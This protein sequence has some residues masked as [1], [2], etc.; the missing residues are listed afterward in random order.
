MPGEVNSKG[1][2]KGLYLAK[3]MDDLKKLA[4]KT[5]SQGRVLNSSVMP[6]TLAK[7]FE[8][9]EKSKLDRDEERAFVLLFRYSDT[10]V[11]AKKQAEDPRFFD[12][13]VKPKTF[14]KC[15]M[16]MEELEQSLSQRYEEMNNP[17]VTNGVDKKVIEKPFDDENMPNGDMVTNNIIKCVEL[18]DFIEDNVCGALLDANPV[19][20]IV[21]CRSSNDFAESKMNMLPMLKDRA[22]RLVLLNI[23]DEILAEGLAMTSLEKKL[24][25]DTKNA[26]KLRKLVKRVILMDWTS[27]ELPKEANHKLT[28]LFNAMWKW[29]NT[30]DRCKMT[31][32]ILKGGYY[33]WV[34]HY[35]QLTTNPNVE[36]PKIYSPHTTPVRLNQIKIDTAYSLDYLDDKK[37]S[38]N[39]A[40][41]RVRNG[42]SIPV[43]Q[44]GVDSVGKP[45]SRP[46]PGGAVPIPS[47]DRTS[48][49][50][51]NGVINL[52][53]RKPLAP[54]NASNVD[55]MD[56]LRRRKEREA[57]TEMQMSLVLDAE[58]R[59]KTMQIEAEKKDAELN[60][61]RRENSELKSRKFVT[62]DTI[63]NGAEMSQKRAISP[64]KGVGATDT[65]FETYSEG[66][67]VDI[68]MRPRQTDRT[69]SE[70]KSTNG[71]LLRRSISG[72]G[73]LS[74]SFS[75]P[76]IAQLIDEDEVLENISQN[77]NRTSITSRPSF[78]R[79]LKPAVNSKSS[80]T[81]FFANM[82]RNRNFSPVYGISGQA[83]TGLKN[84]GN[85]C[86][87][88]SVIQCL[89]STNE[90]AC[91]F[92]SE[93]YVDHLNRNSKFGSRGEL[94]EEF[95]ALVKQLW[96]CQYKSLAPKDLKQ[97]I[98]TH[99]RDF[100][101][102]E[103][104]D[105]HE[106]FTMFMDKISNDL[107]IAT[108]DNT[109]LKIPDDTQTHLAMKKFWAHHSSIM[110][111]IISA[112]FEGLTMSTL[113]CSA[114]G[115]KSE[116]FEVFNSLSL[117]IPPGNR[118]TLNDCLKLFSE[119]EVIR[120][121]AAWDC[122]TCKC[123]REA[124]KRI[125]VCRLP[126]I[127]VIHLKRFSYDGMWRQ[128]LQTSVDFPLEDLS[129]RN[130]RYLNQSDSLANTTYDL[131]GII[132]HSGTM[133]GGH[134]IAHGK[135]IHRGKWYKFDDHEVSE[136]SKADVKTHAAYM[137]FYTSKQQLNGSS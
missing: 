116:T 133:D 69:L 2:A 58:N 118:V 128:K 17:P 8:A 73:G 100:V 110:S 10:Y 72:G 29:D 82:S 77:V 20:L 40:D 16:D 130:Y 9:A 43:N 86:F 132:N 1:L 114:C 121:E 87:M 4:E 95:G 136:I 11:R 135:H 91:Y 37:P 63:G 79:T 14:G 7:V 44:N 123:K 90:L 106:F 111:S 52:D 92:T 28:V 47:I 24:N 103:Q 6:A 94:A 25:V 126:K 74:R 117:P 83:I 108:N 27:D 30:A 23:P 125:Q 49:P 80:L 13:M 93:E 70:S 122:P 66:P 18:Y 119:P 3:S 50:K 51:V 39:E 35:P 127:L 65:V 31:P 97:A 96:T 101:G 55:A 42:G 112:L 21:D 48:K 71:P 98:G 34:S 68:R 26:L 64:K 12:M 75:S 67:D 124:T 60:G 113:V 84:L 32:F 109:I 54:I 41:S 99:M 5:A 131:Y 59:I 137:L 62:G 56:E 120:G 53:V 89:T 105:A 107:N 78:D 46:V 85:T 129:L 57:D 88:N 102:C 115:K 38:L 134:Y 15:V 33:D 104:Q 76:N 81:P 22:N 61:M 19:C 45:N 36:P